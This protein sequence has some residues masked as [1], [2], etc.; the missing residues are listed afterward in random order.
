MRS[1]A[2]ASSE[3]ASSRCRSSRNGQSRKLRSLKSIAFEHRFFSGD[4]R[5]IGALEIPRLH[6]NRLRLRLCLNRGVEAHVPFD[7]KLVLCH[8]IGEGWACRQ[9]VCPF[10]CSCG[11]VASGNNLVEIAPALA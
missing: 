3:A 8:S 11:K 4:K 6:A 10:A 2:K 7:M 9:P 5:A 1:T